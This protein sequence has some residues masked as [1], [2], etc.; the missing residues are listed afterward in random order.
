M[1]RRLLNQVSSA[2]YADSILIWNREDARMQ[3]LPSPG[4]PVKDDCRICF[5]CV[6]P[7]AVANTRDDSHPRL[8]NDPSYQLVYKLLGFKVKNEGGGGDTWQ[9]LKLTSVGIWNLRL[10]TS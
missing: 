1:Q 6:T 2:D 4:S 8:N 7:D 5:T 10:L 9:G 3:T